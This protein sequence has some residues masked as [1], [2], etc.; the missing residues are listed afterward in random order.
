MLIRI[1]LL[2]DRPYKLLIWLRWVIIEYMESHQ[3]LFLHSSMTYSILLDF[4]D[5]PL[6]GADRGELS[7]IAEVRTCAAHFVS[8]KN[9]GQG[10]RT[11]ETVIKQDY[12]KPLNKF[13]KFALG[14]P[15]TASTTACLRE[16]G[17]YPVFIKAYTQCIGYYHRLILNRT[18]SSFQLVSAALHEMEQHIIHG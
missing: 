2:D 1:I 15:K 16:L 17:Q 12:E 8:F 14:V 3:I 11:T 5:F 9:Y 18:K 6:W 7:N 13:M 4:P 10:P